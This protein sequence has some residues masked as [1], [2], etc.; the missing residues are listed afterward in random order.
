MTTPNH[1]K[2]VIFD[3]D[4]VLVD[5]G[6]F[7][8]KS[9]HDIAAQ[10]GFDL[11][12]EF[13]YRTFGMQ[14][15]QILPL[16]LGADAPPDK[17]ERISVAKED[18]FRELIAGRLTLMEGVP[19]L[20]D[21]LKSHGFT[22]AVGSS[23]PR[24]NLE[25]ML[26]QAHALHRFDALVHGQ[27]VDH[28]KPAP[29][30]FLKAAEKLHLPPHRCIVVEDALPGVHAARAADMAVVAITT[31]RSRSDLAP[32]DL[33]IDGMSELNH[34]LFDALLPRPPRIDNT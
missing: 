16:L 18:R 24:V 33:V 27:E 19:A 7:H 30:T 10:E 23:A 4:G 21:D 12:D 5:T 26:R 8:R 14:N 32:A 11:T 15:Y 9:W 20:I 13:F 1:G 25:F 28:G 22:L 3:L 31:T 6:P 34:T 29:D 2:A 17:I